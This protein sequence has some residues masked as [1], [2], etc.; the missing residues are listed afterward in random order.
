M[1]LA[2]WHGRD[3]SV[4]KV[5]ERGLHDEVCASAAADLLLAGVRHGNE[6]QRSRVS[7][8]LPWMECGLLSPTGRVSAA[9]A[10]QLME[11]SEDWYALIYTRGV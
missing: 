5:C 11:C 8:W 4:L 1:L 3:G 10:C 7:K 6:S 9:A 2:N